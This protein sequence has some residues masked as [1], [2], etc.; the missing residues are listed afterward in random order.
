MNAREMR[1]SRRQRVST[2]EVFMWKRPRRPDKKETAER[3]CAVP[4]YPIY[5]STPPHLLQPCRV[6]GCLKS[7]EDFPWRIAGKTRQKRCKACVAR[8][9]AK[10]YANNKE[11]H[12]LGT[13]CNNVAY[14]LRVQDYL[15]EAK[16][17]PCADCGVTYPPWVMQFDHL[18]GEKKLF[19]ISIAPGRFSSLTRI[20]AE[21]KKCEI[22]CANCH[23]QR[24]HKRKQP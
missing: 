15:R 10:W 9:S 17:K 24:T 18:P 8:N 19:H 2:A 1:P 4:C 20:A 3:D 21:I 13:A 6:C 14:R 12:K 11:R 22:V 16:N 7:P 23:C 5:A